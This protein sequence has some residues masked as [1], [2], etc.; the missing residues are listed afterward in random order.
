MSFSVNVRSAAPSSVGITPRDVRTRSR[1]PSTD[2]RICTDC[3]SAG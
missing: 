1:L 2:S 3:E